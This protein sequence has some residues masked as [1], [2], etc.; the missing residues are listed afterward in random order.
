MEESEESI[1]AQIV[2]HMG[3]KPPKRLS[4]VLD[5]AP[6]LGKNKSIKKVA[7]ERTAQESLNI[8]ENMLKETIPDLSQIKEPK[9]FKKG[10][11]ATST[12]K[13]KEIVSWADEV[14][15]EER[16]IPYLTNEMVQL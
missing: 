10:K 14:E 12:P 4:S 1:L 15:I 16:R 8:W 5:L 6:P 2:K 7:T 13:N 3:I 11:R 9:K